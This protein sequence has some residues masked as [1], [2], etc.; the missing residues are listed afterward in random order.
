MKA[1]QNFY[2]NK[3]KKLRTKNP[4]Q[5]HRELKKLTSFDQH[6]SDNVI[7]EAIKDLPSKEQAEIIADKFAEISHEYE[8][9][10]S[11]DIEIPVFS[12]EEIPIIDKSEI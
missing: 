1:K 8:E 4:K 10:K 3:I 12:D 11:E 7:V 2:R 5:W 6:E 9:I